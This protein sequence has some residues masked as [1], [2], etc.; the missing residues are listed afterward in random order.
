MKP[1][2]LIVVPCF[3]EASRLDGQAFL[4]FLGPYP[5]I[6]VLF[7][8]DGSTDT[9]RQ[10]LEN[11]V[12]ARPEQMSL[13]NLPKN[14]GKAE[15]VRQG[16]L[17]GF[18]SFP[19]DLIGYFDADLAT[20]LSTIIELEG[21]FS[22]PSFEIAM[23]SRV[24]LL[25]RNIE[26]DSRRH[27]IGR[28]FATLASMTLGLAVYDTQCGAKLFKVTERLKKVFSFSFTVTWIFDVEILARFMIMERC[29]PTGRAVSKICVEYPVRE[30]IDKKGS[31]VKF[32]HYLT[33]TKDLLK[34]L[35]RVKF[36]P[37]N[38]PYCQKLL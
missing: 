19:V 37:Q 6:H 9:T 26:R 11:F 27:Y 14:S 3:N 16:F 24:K 31:K 17:K 18:L 23:G 1:K 36:S 13:L 15:A 25:G 8:N 10:V 35:F 28:I 21:L 30:W 4:D 12:K 32:W 20:P 33:S 29:H 7:V 2:T 38:H 34:I 5:H 22:N